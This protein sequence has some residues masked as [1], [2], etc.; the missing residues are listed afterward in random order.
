[1]WFL[2]SLGGYFSAA[3]EYEPLLHT[4]SLAVEEQFYVLFP[5]II[6]ALARFRRIVL[7]WVIVAI[8]LAS[9][10]ASIWAT[11]AYPFANFFSLLTRAWELGIG[12]LL[13]T[14]FIRPLGFVA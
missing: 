4:W 6:W 3:A 7:S 12:A 9:L 8:S 2:K 1:M 14:G 10:A 11:Q 13:A 5:L